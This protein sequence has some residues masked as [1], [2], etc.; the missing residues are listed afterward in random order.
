MP[1]IKEFLQA[2][3]IPI[4]ELPGFEAD[5]IIGTLA[6]HASQKVMKYVV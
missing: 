5:D 1:R 3:G 6:H 4:L 2:I